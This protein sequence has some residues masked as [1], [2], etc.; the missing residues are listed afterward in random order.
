MRVQM[1][2]LLAL[3]ATASSAFA[4]SDARR[5]AS[6]IDRVAA[7]P[8]EPARARPLN[9]MPPARPVLT[10]LR[11]V[12]GCAVLLVREGGRVIEEPVYAPERRRIF[13]P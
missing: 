7:R 2:T 3:T 10:V 1:F 6:G 4:R 5:C 9:E 13:R 11:E 8:A 12:D